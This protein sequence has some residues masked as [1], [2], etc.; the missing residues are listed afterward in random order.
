MGNDGFKS[1]FS[2]A[3]GEIRVPEEISSHS[4]QSQV[5]LV[6][7]FC[8]HDYIHPVMGNSPLLETV[9]SIL[10]QVDW[11]GLSY[12]QICRAPNHWPYFW[13]LELHRK[14]LCHKAAHQRPE[15]KL[16][17][18]CLYWFSP[19]SCPLCPHHCFWEPRPLYSQRMYHIHKPRS[20][21]ATWSWTTFVCYL[22]CFLWGSDPPLKYNSI[23]CF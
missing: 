15:H 22:E 13:S 7:S 9:H 1:Y 4:A 11:K 21:E 14:G 6:S 12:S 18:C 2:R 19:L 23:P 3:L 16:S 17:R 5:G 10:R 8:W 20:T